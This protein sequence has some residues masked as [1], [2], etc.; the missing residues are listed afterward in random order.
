M[1][2]NLMAVLSGGDLIHY[3]LGN[4]PIVD[5]M[6]NPKV[7]AGV[8][9]I[10]LSIGKVEKIASTGTVGFDSQDT[11]LPSML[12]VRMDESTHLDS[13]A[14]KITYNEEIHVPM[15][16]VAIA[17]PRSTLLRLGATVE[18]ALWDSGYQGQSESLLLV[19][20][21]SGLELRKNARVVQLVFLKGSQRVMKGYSGRYQKEH[22]SR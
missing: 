7:Q 20:N 4:P 5:K 17:R 18:T 1:Q 16:F 6:V 2:G 13:G 21:P 19:H 8:N 3:L 10:E 22:L 14:Y 9:G 12:E 15:N 11:K